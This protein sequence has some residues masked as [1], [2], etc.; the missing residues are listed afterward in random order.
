MSTQNKNVYLLKIR[1]IFCLLFLLLISTSLMAKMTL[2]GR[3]FIELPDRSYEYDEI[4][5]SFF[6][7]ESEMVVATTST[8][9]N[10]YYEITLK[11]GTYDILFEKGK[12]YNELK[13][14]ELYSSP[15]IK[16]KKINDVQLN[17]LL[18]ERIKLKYSLGESKIISYDKNYN[19][20][21]FELLKSIGRDL[22]SFSTLTYLG[23]G[24]S[25]IG[26]T[27]AVSSD[28]GGKKIGIGIS[29]IGG[30]I[31]L[32]APA[33][34]GSA[35]KKLEEFAKYKYLEQQKNKT[36]KNKVKD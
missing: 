8:D 34:V 25:I 2:Q 24:I 1:F 15:F 28:K 23:F 7:V 21:E 6:N 18:D 17:K 9:K 36:D 26:T 31:S 14:I 11:D 32:T 30:I 13:E 19:E 12:Y 16:K 20:N 10:G 33:K 35:G 27:I 22:K 29:V 4:S 5:I 3:A